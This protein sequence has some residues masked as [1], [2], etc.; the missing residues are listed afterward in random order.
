MDDAA[1]DFLGIKQLAVIILFNHKQLRHFHLLIGGK[2]A[3]AVDALPAAAYAAALLR[4]AGIDNAAVRAIAEL[5][6][7]GAALLW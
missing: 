5:A 4:R 7:H 6:L 3:A 2:A 1:A